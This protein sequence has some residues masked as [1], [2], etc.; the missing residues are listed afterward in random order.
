LKKN[1]AEKKCL[2]T[3]K[4]KK[5]LWVELQSLISGNFIVPIPAITLQKILWWVREQLLS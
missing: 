4:V 3:H 5:T 1:S 2:W